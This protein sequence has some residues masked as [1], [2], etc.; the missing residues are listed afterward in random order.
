MRT[1]LL[2]GLALFAV[3]AVAAWQLLDLGGGSTPL[4]V[5]GGGT[6]TEAPAAGIGSEEGQAP[7]GVPEE[8]SGRREL[9]TT[10]EAGA[11]VEDP[12]WIAALAGLEGR[13]VEAED[14]TPLPGVEVYVAELRLDPLLVDLASLAGD[15]LTRSP[16]VIKAR[17]RTDDDGRFRFAGLCVRSWHVIGFGA[18]TDKVGFRMQ[19]MALG[20]GQSRDLGDIRVAPRGKV[21]G[22]V[23]GPDGA[24]MA[25]AVVRAVHVPLVVAEV[26]LARFDFEGLLVAMQ[27]SFGFVLPVPSWIREVEPDLPFPA[28]RTAADG[29][30]ELVG[31]AEGMVTLLVQP[32]RGLACTKNTRVH[33]HETTGPMRIK[34]REGKVLE[35]Q[36]VDEAGQPV[37]GVEVSAGER[38]GPVP[39][40]FMPKPVRSDAEGKVRI[41]GLGRNKQ[42]VVLRRAADAR[43]TVAGEFLPGE[44]MRLVVPSL[45][46]GRVRVVTASGAPAEDVHLVVEDG[47]PL[48]MVAGMGRRYATDAHVSPIDDQPGTYRLHDLETGAYRVVARAKGA[49]LASGL[50]ELGKGAD[51]APLV[52]TVPEAQALRFE[53]TDRG[54]RPVAGAH[55]HWIASRSR[56]KTGNRANDWRAR[57]AENP[58]FLGR[59]GADGSLVVRELERGASHFIARHPAHGMAGT[60]DQGASPDGVVRIVLPAAATIEGRLTE[61]GRPPA[62]RHTVYVE[63][64]GDSFRRFHALLMPMFTR[65]AEDGS[66]RLDGLTPGSYRLEVLPDF[67]ANGTPMH[68]FE[69][70]ATQQGQ[71]GVRQQLELAEGQV[72]RLDLDTASR[73]VKGAGILEGVVRRNGRPVEGLTVQAWANGRIAGTTDAQGR[74]RFDGLAEA[75]HQVVV[76]H[77]DLASLDEDRLWQGEV[78]LTKDKV[79]FLDIDLHTTKFAFRLVDPDGGPLPVTGL[80]LEKRTSKASPANA[81][82]RGRSDADGVVTFDDIEIG[83]YAV[84]LDWEARRRGIVL[85]GLE[86]DVQPGQA[87]PYELGTVKGLSV[88]GTITFD[89]SRLS[90]EERALV[91]EQVRKQR[92]AWKQNKQSWRGWYQLEADSGGLQGE[93]DEFAFSVQNI[94]PGTHR[95]RGWIDGLQWTS[96]D[97]EVRGDRENVRV[98]LRPEPSDLERRLKQKQAREQQAGK[99]Q[100]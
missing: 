33:P 53:V 43:W 11:V 42:H 88:K 55:V 16:V 61:N 18:G 93:G 45:A 36:V 100:G 66:F 84:R 19:T 91:D 98:Q 62:Q 78:D 63:P 99:K 22:T 70:I 46:E 57:I 51:Q 54:G 17:A 65:S 74:F 59:T 75:K 1:R 13:L 68:F 60:M 9:E 94:A 86:V 73:E 34:I 3:V 82:Y 37:A 97:I 6:G 21:K 23:T 83:T 47:D 71:Q 8:A 96:D 89:L 28:T 26:G 69:Q 24:P 20:A 76:M 67:A 85:P 77:M 7:R 32:T 40:A 64:R 95:M 2:L 35:G 92:E 58:V 52:L 39:F 49:G 87:G 4:T 50:I 79:A 10:V 38:V 56:A 5:D 30:F 41:D 14:G 27:G 90:P 25:G 31:V 81:G 44:D 29:S 48:V 80:R 15:A 12:S 72:L